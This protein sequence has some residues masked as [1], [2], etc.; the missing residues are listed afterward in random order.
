M[1]ECKNAETTTPY[2]QDLFEIHLSGVREQQP[3][4]DEKLIIPESSDDLVGLTNAYTQDVEADRQRGPITLGL[5]LSA[6]PDDKAGVVRF[7]E[8]PSITSTFA[9]YATTQDVTLCLY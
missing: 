1:I 9:Q 2:S 6:I 7:L 3:S 8:P 4:D 5:A